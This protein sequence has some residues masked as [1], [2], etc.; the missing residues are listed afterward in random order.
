MRSRG[1][2]QELTCQHDLGRR[3]R[4][5]YTEIITAFNILTTEHGQRLHA[6]QRWRG[7]ADPPAGVGGGLRAVVVGFVFFLFFYLNT[8]VEIRQSA[9]FASDPLPGLPM[10]AA[11]VLNLCRESL[12]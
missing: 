8:N 6:W 3:S 1:A 2:S 11:D 7:H 9:A 5:V 4:A 10:A 12:F